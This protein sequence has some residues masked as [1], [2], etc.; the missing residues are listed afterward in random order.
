MTDETRRRQKREE[1]K[2]KAARIIESDRK[3]R[4]GIVNAII[5]ARRN[6]RKPYS[7]ESFAAEIRGLFEDKRRN[8]KIDY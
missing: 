3:R 7:P 5:E 8:T 1:L 6:R 4:L 2:A